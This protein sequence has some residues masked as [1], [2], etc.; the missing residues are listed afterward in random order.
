M[1]ILKLLYHY[2]QC[3]RLNFSDR[4]QLSRY[5][6][7]KL[8]KFMKT[9]LPKSPYFR[10]YLDKP[11]QDFPLMNKQI[12]MDNFDQLNTARLKL[13]D[14]L[15][16]A[17]QAE[18]SRDFSPTIGQ[19]SV[20]LSSGTSGKRGVF[21]VSPEEQAKWAGTILAKLLPNG[22]FHTE[23]IAF[24]L[25]ANNN[26][27]NSVKS[28]TISFEFFDLFQPFEQSIHRL[29]AYQPTIIVAPAQVL[30]QLALDERVQSLNVNKVISVAEVLDSQTKQLLT[31]RFPE[32]GEVYQATEGFLACTCRCGNLHLNEDLLIVEQQMLDKHRFVPIIT[33][34]SRISQPIVRYR[35]D[36]VLVKHPDPCPCGS[37][38]QRI[39]KIEGRFSDTLKL[40]GKDQPEVL[41]FA[42]LCERI[43]AQILPLEA[44]YQLDQIA[45]NQLKLTACCDENQL[46]QC[47]H[48]FLEV[49]EQLGV[50]TPQI[51]WQLS[52]LPIERKLADKRRRVRN[53]VKE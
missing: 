14:V 10:P 37:V 52:R 15:N 9:V 31:Q 28:R 25:R 24:F 50:D 1:N 41:V 20:G 16:C 49:F 43:F 5:Q 21:L 4:L 19:Y 2:W 13:Q 11:L 29:Q 36:D 35:L 48:K 17:L 40:S 26:L 7:R 30:Y 6:Q 3:K 47:Q 18:S 38:L 53:L 46:K 8:V 51:S 27:Y 44:D 42:D 22:L 33:D 23:R 45:K 34:F 32:V 12:M 39:E